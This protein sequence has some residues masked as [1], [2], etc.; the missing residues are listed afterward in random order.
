MATD[1]NASGA[2]NIGSGTTD[3]SSGS[4][5]IGSNTKPITTPPTPQ[6]K[7]PGSEVDEIL[8]K[9]EHKGNWGGVIPVGWEKPKE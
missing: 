9:I 1:S 7:P 6:P 8:N 2:A 4:T 5:I 3:V